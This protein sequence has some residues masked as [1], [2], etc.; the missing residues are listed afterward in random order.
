MP[1]YRIFIDE[2]GQAKPNTYPTSPYFAL[3]G[4]M[5]DQKHGQLLKQNLDQLKLKYFGRKSHVLHAADLKCQLKSNNKSLTNFAKDLNEILNS[6]Y[7]FLLYAVVDKKQ[8]VHRGWNMLAV[9]KKTYKILLENMLKFLVAKDIQGEIFAEASNF[10]QDR[11]L[12][13]TF[14][15]F[16]RLGIPQLAISH[17]EAKKYLTSLSFVTK[18][19]NDAEEQLADMFG[20]FA[21]LKM[22]LDSNLRKFDQLNEFEK[23]IY[24]VANKRLFKANT[25]TKKQNKIRLYRAINAFTILP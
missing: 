19:H 18:V 14:H 12:Y 15:H 16:I 25:T 2:S 1:N 24:Q 6:S 13:T 5:I 23:V 10:T 7:F 9:Y 21:K 3:C 17:N 11:Y 4:V 22:Q 8:S 20:I